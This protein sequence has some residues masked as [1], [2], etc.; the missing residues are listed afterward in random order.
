MRNVNKRAIFILNL[1]VIALVFYTHIEADGS[2]II[3]DTALIDLSAEYLSTGK[4]S[5]WSNEG[6]VKGGFNFLSLFTPK[7]QMVA[8]R[9]AVTFNGNQTMRSSFTAPEGITGNGDFSVAIW[10]YNP[11]IDEEE[12]MLSWS[13]RGGPRGT[14]AEIL[15]GNHWSF[16]AVGHWGPDTDMGYDG[17]LPPAKQW[18][19]I[20]VTFDGK[21]EKVYV[22]GVLN[23]KESKT[24]NIYSNK[25][26]LIGSADFLN[27]FSG[28]IAS[29]YIFDYAL[30]QE[31]IL[32]LAG[33]KE[34][35]TDNALVHLDANELSF[36]L[37]TSWINKGSL[38]G[39]FDT[40][41]PIVKM[42]AGRKA[43]GF[44]GFTVLESTFSAPIGITGISD[45]TLELW[46]YSSLERGQTI[47]SWARRPENCAQFVWDISNLAFVSW[48]GGDFFYGNIPA[49]NRWHHIVY[50][51]ADGQNTPFN[52]YIDGILDN[53]SME[54][55]PAPGIQAFNIKPNDKIVI[56]GIYDSDKIV[57]T[58]QGYIS[59]VRIYDQALTA[60]EVVQLYQPNMGLEQ[61]ERDIQQYERS[62]NKKSPQNAVEFL[63][64]KIEEFE[65][66]KNK[67][68]D[69]IGVSYRHFCEEVSS[70]LL[71]LL[72]E[73]RVASGNY[74]DDD[75]AKEYIRA[76]ESNTL[77]VSKQGDALFWLYT[78][79]PATRYSEIGRICLKSHPN[80]LKVIADK[81][82]M[83]IND[84]KIKEAM[85]FLEANIHILSIYKREAVTV[86]KNMEMM[87][88]EL[89]FYLAQAKEVDG[90]PVTDITHEYKRALQS[91][92]LSSM[93]LKRALIWLYENTDS[94]DYKEIVSSTFNNNGVYL[95]GVGELAKSLV[96]ENKPKAAIKFLETILDEYSKWHINN[97]QDIKFNDQ[98]GILYSELAKIK[99]K[100]GLS[101]SEVAVAY[102]R[103][104]EL[105]TVEN[106]SLRTE[107]I[108]WSLENNDSDESSDFV[109]SILGNKATNRPY[110]NV[111]GNLCKHF[112]STKNWD[113]FKSFLELLL[114]N[115]E[116][117]LNWMSYVE[118]YLS[119]NTSTFTSK[120][121]EFIETQPQSKF[122]KELL[123]AEDYKLKGDFKKAAEAYEAIVRS[124]ES[125]DYKAVCEL[126]IYDC[127]IKAGQ[128]KEAICLYETF[129]SK[130]KQSQNNLVKKAILNLGRCYVNL[131]NLDKA[132]EWFS[133]LMDEY[134]NT[135]E[136]AQ[137]NYFV[138]Y[139][140]ILQGEFDQAKEALNLVVKDYPQ[141]SYASKA[142]LCLTRIE[143]MTE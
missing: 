96:D 69:V 82:N 65:K 131:G 27:Y 33:K 54:Y 55:S 137:S 73:A 106:V 2:S 47:L 8:G 86:N 123:E 108:V 10:V 6:T 52:I 136:A 19:Y 44:D 28:S 31:E 130:N 7:V 88:R 21:V 122:K 13:R 17:G 60:G 117:P 85:G 18:H 30:A 15:Y 89:Y 84:N 32:N 121:Y 143:S 90:M 139:C 97:P 56:G 104:L 91:G 74:S 141:S 111:V 64:N 75:I 129:I 76:I 132:I 50:T 35:K 42:V 114:D 119:D 135:N 72:A 124:C 63:R 66:W 70:N 87:E 29:V 140:Y 142:R 36:G 3:A 99:G 46:I 103:A 40:G 93:S 113:M 68:Y 45:W 105:S 61:F 138:G 133:N 20:A 115:T 126:E 26:I 59:C 53:S 128:E 62:F 110:T 58:F 80:Y 78:N 79:L 116:Y 94:Q 81:A 41:A 100:S 34:E 1:M 112:E 5:H 4:L 92:L 12:T 51:K 16:G 9:K 102:S 25:P 95:Y 57:H 23:V 125:E 118:S 71:F 98:V 43:L 83:L 120:Y 38:G 48:G 109:S 22:D 67:N 39:S 37:L 11:V 77:S 49:P 107:A 14:N 127:M 24:L 134:P 101:K